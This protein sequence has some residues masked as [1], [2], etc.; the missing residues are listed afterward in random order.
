METDDGWTTV[1]KKPKKSEGSYS[2][3]NSGPG[4]ED[5]SEG[6]S[7]KTSRQLNKS[8]GVAQS[9]PENTKHYFKNGSGTPYNQPNTPPNK[10]SS[11]YVPPSQRNNTNDNGHRYKYSPNGGPKYPPN[12]YKNNMRNNSKNTGPGRRNQTIANIPDFEN[13]EER[14]KFADIQKICSHIMLPGVARRT[15][16][17]LRIDNFAEKFLSDEWIERQISGW[18][19]ERVVK[20][21]DV[22]CEIPDDDN[23]ELVDLEN[24]WGDYILFKKVI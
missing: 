11:K 5:K 21:D 3:S 2:I 24:K 12:G 13:D 15:A 17:S 6:I 18:K 4:K 9:K 23:H 20:P 8:D 16:L 7:G 10:E 1:V 19:Y 14:N 22:E